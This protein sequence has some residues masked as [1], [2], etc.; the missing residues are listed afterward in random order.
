MA[1]IAEQVQNHLQYGNVS[2]EQARIE[3][4]E[5]FSH[6]HFDGSLQWACFIDGSFLGIEKENLNL[7]LIK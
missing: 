5:Q 7:V 3:E 4:S 1:T 2:F 6:Y